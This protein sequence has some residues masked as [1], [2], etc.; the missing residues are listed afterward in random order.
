[1]INFTM[2]AAGNE[3]IFFYRYSGT[4]RRLLTVSTGLPYF[5]PLPREYRRNFPIYRNRGITAFPIT[6]S[7]SNTQTTGLGT[8]S[9]T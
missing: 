6:V 1:M 8:E 9:Q 4:I 7:L 2:H 3:L 5:L